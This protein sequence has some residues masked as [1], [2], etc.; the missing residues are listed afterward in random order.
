MYVRVYNTVRSWLWNL[1]YIIFFSEMA[2]QK[3][4][5]N[6]VYDFKKREERILVHLW[7]TRKYF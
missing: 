6:H 5:K 7:V 1:D 2:Y 3:N 4:A